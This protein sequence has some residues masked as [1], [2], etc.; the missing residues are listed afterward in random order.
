MCSL[1][2]STEMNVSIHR[3]L[4]RGV[5][6]YVT[7]AILDEFSSTSLFFIKYITKFSGALYLLSSW[8]F[9][10]DTVESKMYIYSNEKLIQV[11]YFPENNFWIFGRWSS[12]LHVVPLWLVLKWYYSIYRSEVVIKVFVVFLTKERSRNCAVKKKHLFKASV[13]SLKKIPW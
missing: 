10:R 13:C 4:A 9:E 2:L 6:L 12:A 11:L 5:I 3:I 8:A 1:I 7:K